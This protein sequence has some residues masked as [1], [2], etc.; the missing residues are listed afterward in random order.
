MRQDR[1]VDK[2]L[3]KVIDDQELQEDLNDHHNIQMKEEEWEG[4]QGHS[5]KLSMIKTNEGQEV[6]DEVAVLQVME[7]RRE[8][9]NMIRHRLTHNKINN[10]WMINL[11]ILE[12][13]KNTQIP[14][15]I[16]MHNS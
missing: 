1:E 7:G 9:D 15:G 13:Y 4:T 3:L 12:V 5:N 11:V 6:Q 8:V 14:I 2:V 16:R 10:L